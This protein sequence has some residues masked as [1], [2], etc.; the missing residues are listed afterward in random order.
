MSMRG[1]RPV[2]QLAKTT[3]EDDF[4]HRQWEARLRY[5][6]HRVGFDRFDK[7][8][9]PVL[10]GSSRLVV[11]PAHSRSLDH[12]I[13]TH[14]ATQE[15]KARI[16]LPLAGTIVDGRRGGTT[17]T[18]RRESITYL[19]QYKRITIQ[20]VLRST[21]VR[22]IQ[23]LVDDYRS[24]KLRGAALCAQLDAVHARFGDHYVMEAAVGVAFRMDKTAAN[25]SDFEELHAAVKVGGVAVLGGSTADGTSGGGGIG[26][27]EVS[28]AQKL[29]RSAASEVGA[30][31]YV[32]GPMKG[33][34]SE[35]LAALDPNKWDEMAVWVVKVGS[36]VSLLPD[37]LRKSLEQ[38]LDEVSGVTPNCRYGEF[39]AD[40]RCYKGT[41]SGAGDA[42]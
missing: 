7:A 8:A 4:L 3:P 2:L 26:E 38:C 42:S 41:P 30:T 35:W 33:S 16:T 14:D 17:A 1:S 29:A 40:K 9:S 15:T 19:H 13:D 34:F 23:Q 11:L 10:K 32:G 22:E 36:V 12:R 25:S 20:P 18:G 28:G 39:T 24:N 37:V 6:H 31:E 21:Y 5:G 27:I